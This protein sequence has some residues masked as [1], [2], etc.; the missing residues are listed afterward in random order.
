M[1]TLIR[2]KT[3]LTLDS[4]DHLYQPGFI[5]IENNRIIEVGQSDR[6]DPSRHFD[7]TIDLPDR[8]LMPGLINTHTHSPMVLFRG[9]A[10]GHSLFTFDGWFKTVRVVEQVMEADM[11]PAAV[12]VSC[13]EMI[14]TG[15]TCFADQYFWMDHIVPQVRRSKMRAV[16]CYGIVELG[17]KSARDRELQSAGLFLE[18]VQGDPLISGWL[19][20][21]AFFVD[22]SEDAIKMELKLADQYNAGLHFHLATSG[23]EDRYCQKN[24]GCS[25]AVRM[26]QIG[27]LDHRLLAAHGIT[28]PQEDF[29]LL[30]KHPF[31]I[32]AAPSSAMKNAAGFAPNKAMW[33]SGINLALGTD[34]VTNNNSYDMFK[35]MQLLGKVT[36]M[37][38]REVNV[39]PTREIIRMATM[40]GAKALGM[41]KEIGSLEV[42]KKADLISLDLGE[43]GWAPHGFQDLF[44][45]IVYSI[46]GQHVRDVMIDGEWVFRDNQLTMID[47]PAA[48]TQLE[49]DC[50]RLK[51]RVAAKPG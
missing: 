47:Y 8:L 29:A 32:V 18:S 40:G 5:V 22:N 14:R 15:T 45:S 34:N 11:L 41:E 39:I 4:K 36:S 7:S 9:M 37:L 44:T 49:S 35:E 38:E 10:E 33:Q 27:L 23:E 48:C 1:T 28:V 17:E 16:L 24:Y 51:Q 6:L 26:K 12:T 13:A 20:P 50:A 19:G 3:I 31:T 46:T 42:G 30:A 25:A 2:A 21:H 43:I